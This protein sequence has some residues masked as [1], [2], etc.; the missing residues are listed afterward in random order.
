MTR[1]RC[2]WT[3]ALLALCGRAV[4]LAM[5]AGILARRFIRSLYHD[6]LPLLVILTGS[7]LWV[8]AAYEV[9]R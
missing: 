6:G 1:A 3:D 9:T 5:V 8:A 4:I 7:I 2:T